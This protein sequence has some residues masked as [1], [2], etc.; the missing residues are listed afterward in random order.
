MTCCNWPW[1][2]VGPRSPVTKCW[3]LHVFSDPRLRGCH[4]RQSGHAHRG[5]PIV[6]GSADRAPAR[7][8]DLD[9]IQERAVLDKGRCL[10]ARDGQL[11]DRR[12]QLPARE[13][14]MSPGSQHWCHELWWHWH[15]PAHVGVVVGSPRYCCR[16]NKRI[17]GGEHAEQPVQHTHTTI[18]SYQSLL[19][20]Y[21]C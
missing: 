16:G 4:G 14:P 17:Y 18:R 19:N 12:P 13:R 3:A 21:C 20:R 5:L 1:T 8:R 7:R 6:T 11:T 2:P 9:E 15:A 10:S